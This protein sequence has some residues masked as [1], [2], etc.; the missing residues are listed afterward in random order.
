MK[1]LKVYE[2]KLLLT[3]WPSEL[4]ICRS[5][6]GIYFLLTSKLEINFSAQGSYANKYFCEKNG[7]HHAQTK[8]I[9]K[10]KNTL[11]LGLDYV[12]KT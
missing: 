7:D 11:K 10:F 4:D 1:K 12:K 3:Y 9:L 8:I 5:N 6:R 2:W